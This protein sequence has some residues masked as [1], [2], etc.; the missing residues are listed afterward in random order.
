M[1]ALPAESSSR[2]TERFPLWAQ[3]IVGLIVGSFIGAM[4]PSFGKL[5]EP[6]G[7]AFV[8][9]IKMVIIPLLFAAVTLATY[10]MGADIKRLGKMGLTAFGWF[11]LGTG[12]AMAVGIGLNQLIHPGIGVPIE[13]T[14]SIPNNLAGSID[15]VKFFLDMI[16]DNVVSV[17]ANHKIIPFL[18]FC[19]AF[20]L[21]LAAVKE[22]AKPIADILEALLDTMLK[23]TMGVISF[24]PFATGAIM[25]WLFATQGMKMV[26]ALAQLVMAAYL[27]LLVLTGVFC[28]L[29]IILGYNPLDTFKKISTGLLL[30]FAT[31]SSEVTLPSILEALDEMGIN[32][33]ISAFSIPLGYSFNL[34]GSAFYQALAVSFLCDVYGVVLDGPTLITILI[35]AVIANKGTANVPSASL[36]VISL[37]LTTLGLP[38]EGIAIIAGVD[39]LIDGVRCVI[40]VFGNVTCTIVLNRLFGKGLSD[41]A[42]QAESSI[43]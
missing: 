33:R 41:D 22:R 26:M 1:N 12:I 3:I 42:D 30:A 40:N 11:Y 29:L 18:V 19:I 39:R 7:T 35:T 13:A 6:I 43:I 23:M 34:D 24:A 37:I 16:P 4:W 28:I 36:V 2:K 32:Y 27:G 20:G 31:G 8:K 25:A 9:G 10:R 38:V 15:W 21:S 5:L 14:G 17:A